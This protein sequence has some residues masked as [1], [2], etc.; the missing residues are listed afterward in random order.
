M[1][2]QDIA[3]EEDDIRDIRRDVLTFGVHTT[4]EEWAHV[5]GML[6]ALAADSLQDLDK[7]KKATKKH[8]PV[9]GSSQAVLEDIMVATPRAT[10]APFTRVEAVVA[11]F[12]SRAKDLLS[13]LTITEA[14]WAKRDKSK[15]ELSVVDSVRLTTARRK[16]LKLVVV[17]EVV[18]ARVRA[19]AVEAE[20]DFQPIVLSS[21]TQVAGP[22]QADSWSALPERLRIELSR[23]MSDPVTLGA[24]Y[25]V[26][27]AKVAKG[28]DDV[29]RRGPNPPTAP[30]PAGTRRSITLR[31]M[32]ATSTSST[33]LVYPPWMRIGRRT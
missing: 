12:C 16:L 22:T 29:C 14:L 27:L 20:D 7:L 11:S 9:V 8:V 25:A 33:R 24:G 17:S 31:R 28:D 6:D 3:L 21:S 26:G 10:R 19:D 1:K 32:A 13:L 5:T 2:A 15:A 18:E 4:D 30:S 23:R